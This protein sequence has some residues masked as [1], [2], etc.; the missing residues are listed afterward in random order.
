M[1]KGPRR[2]RL[3]HFLDFGKVINRVCVLNILISVLNVL[4][5]FKIYTPSLLWED[6]L[7]VQNLNQIPTTNIHKIRES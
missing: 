2:L 1:L 7:H 3:Y 6:G 5:E 4:L